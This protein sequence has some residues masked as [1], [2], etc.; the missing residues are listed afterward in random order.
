MLCSHQDRNTFIVNMFQRNKFPVNMSAN[1]MFTLVVNCFKTSFTPASIIYAV[2]RNK[3]D[4]PKN[5]KHRHDI[6]AYVIRLA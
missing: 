4:C 5:R 2:L 6:Y 1:S 3:H